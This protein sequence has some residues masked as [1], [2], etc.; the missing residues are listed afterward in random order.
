MFRQRTKACR[1][2]AA[3]IAWWLSGC[4][5]AVAA[6][7]AAA[8]ACSA[9]SA[10]LRRCTEAAMSGAT[11][12]GRLPPVITVSAAWQ[13]RGGWVRPGFRRRGPARQWRLGGRTHPSSAGGLGWSAGAALPCRQRKCSSSRA[14]RLGT[15]ALG[16]RWFWENALGTLLGCRKCQG[17]GDRVQQLGFHPHTPNGRSSRSRLA[18]D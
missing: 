2:P 4:R 1:P 13:Q 6:R 12:A 10:L 15:N 7:L 5:W 11:D 9:A 3:T 16:R 17:E 18:L 8:A 14:A